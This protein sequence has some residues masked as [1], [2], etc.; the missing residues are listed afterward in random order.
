M[1]FCKTQFLCKKELR[2]FDRPHVLVMLKCIVKEYI[3]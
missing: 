1:I 2:F 3:R